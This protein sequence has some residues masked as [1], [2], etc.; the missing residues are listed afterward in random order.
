M[1]KRYNNSHVP[2]VEYA[3]DDREFVIQASQLGVKLSGLGLGDFSKDML[4]LQ[5]KVHNGAKKA[6]RQMGTLEQGKAQEIERNVVGHSKSGYVPTGN[7]NEHIKAHYPRKS[8]KIEVQVYPK[9][10]NKGYNYG[11]SVEF[12]PEFGNKHA[13]ATPY[14]KP[15]ADIINQKFDE[16][17]ERNLK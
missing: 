8:E 16:V 9:V 6:I 1:S 5:K 12:A 10:S 15:S 7:L 2:I 4:K 3:V 17:L 11:Q 14:M 13:A